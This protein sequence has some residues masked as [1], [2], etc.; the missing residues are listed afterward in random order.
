MQKVLAIPVQLSNREHSRIVS[1][2]LRGV[3]GPPKIVVA[4]DNLKGGRG[5]KS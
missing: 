4:A 5:I 2:C 3:G 1:T